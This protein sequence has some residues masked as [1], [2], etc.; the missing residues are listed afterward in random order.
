MVDV[1]W[2]EEVGERWGMGGF[3]LVREGRKT[4]ANQARPCVVT[5]SIETPTPKSDGPVTTCTT[6]F[7]ESSGSLKSTATQLPSSKDLLTDNPQVTRWPVHGRRGLFG[8]VNLSRFSI[9]KLKPKA[10][11]N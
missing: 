8:E 10:P 4:A 7:M 11:N 1:R 9:V 2:M 3:Y 5:N 6:H